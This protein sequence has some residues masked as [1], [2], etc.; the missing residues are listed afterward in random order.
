[1]LGNWKKNWAAG[2]SSLLLLSALI[3]VGA[4]TA[5]AA[6]TTAIQDSGQ[7]VFR[8]VALGDS[9]TAGYEPGMTDVNTKPYGYAERLLEQGWYHGR[10]ALTNYG[11]L[12]LTTAGLRNYTGAIKDGSVITADGVQAGL[13]DPR[14]EQFVKLTPQIAAEL[15]EADLITITIGGNDVSSL[16]L[17]FKELTDADFQTQ[18]DQR[19][20]DYQTNVKAVL[21]NIRAVSPQATIILA[22]QYQPAP[23]VALGQMYNRLMTAAGKFTEAADSVAASVNQE[24]AKVLVAH[25]AAKFAG[26]EGSLTHIIGAGQTDFHP[27]QLGYET[28]A[29]VFTELQWGEYRVPTVATMATASVPM[30]IVVKG[31]ELNTPNKPILKNGQNFLALKDILNAV[32]ASGKWDNKTSSA[33]IVY[34][35]RTVVITIGSK[36]IKVNGE[37]VAID[38]PAFLQKVG[39]EDKTY[40][41]LAA[42][43]TGLGFDVNYS[44]KLRTAFINP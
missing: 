5:N 17:Q 24:G 11:I 3:S 29:K 23:K 21:E 43:A 9:I 18:L 1:M 42:L 28:I 7:D 44:S 6:D 12:G 19:L 39:K 38:T 25:V 13:P 16:F 36:F 33:T 14:I 40:L 32:G 30:S 31:V 4:G 20:A 2:I 35:G 8:I 15:K 27:T 26:V 41:P 34:G 10:S 37:N 22:D